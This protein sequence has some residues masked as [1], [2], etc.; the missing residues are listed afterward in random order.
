MSARLFFTARGHVKKKR[1][2]R[3]GLCLLSSFALSFETKVPNC[4]SL[5]AR[6]LPATKSRLARPKPALPDAALIRFPRP[7]S[8]CGPRLLPDSS[9]PMPATTDGHDEAAE[10]RTKY[11]VRRV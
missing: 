8:R 3:I 2:Q 9:R 4:S 5:K 1:H 6:R 10:R 11:H 7:T